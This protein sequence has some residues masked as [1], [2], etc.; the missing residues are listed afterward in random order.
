MALNAFWPDDDPPL[1]ITAPEGL[2]AWW[3]ELSAET[4]RQRR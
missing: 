2:M 4:L 1:F 3:R